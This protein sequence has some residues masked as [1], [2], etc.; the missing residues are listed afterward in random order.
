MAG[1]GEGVLV[2]VAAG[3]V[4]VETEPVEGVEADG[5][6]PQAVS[7]R[8]ERSRVRRRRSAAIIT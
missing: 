6:N 5:A 2:E 4:A 3:R 8:V 7:R 1:V